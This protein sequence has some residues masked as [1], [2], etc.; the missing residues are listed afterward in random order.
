MTIESKIREIVEKALDEYPANDMDGDIVESGVDFLVHALL[1]SEEIE[2][3][4]REV[5]E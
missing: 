5:G 4:L 3:K 2:V 1:S